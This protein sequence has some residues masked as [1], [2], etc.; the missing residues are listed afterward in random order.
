MEFAIRI[1]LNELELAKSYQ[2]ETPIRDI[3]DG[4]RR[5]RTRLGDLYM[6]DEEYAKA[7]DEYRQ[8]ITQEEQREDAESNRLIA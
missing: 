3:L 7:V 5:A 6:L 4:L 8:V 2:T 1:F